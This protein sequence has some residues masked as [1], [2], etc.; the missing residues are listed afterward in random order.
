MLRD[1]LHEEK[2]MK[3]FATTDLCDANED[4]LGAGT[5]RVLTPVFRPFGRAERFAGPASTLKVFEDN[6]LVRTA[7][8]ENGDGR[9]LVIDGGGSIRCAIVGGNLAMLAE[10]NGW[11]GVLVYGAVRD[12]AELNAC[13]IGIRALAVHP[14]RSQKR[15]VGERDLAI[16]LP[17][18]TVRPGEWIYADADGILVSTTKLD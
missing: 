9:V 15:S 8:E 17:G 1:L 13:N 10:K 2:P 6:T 5:L 12:T 7:L 14:Q 4:R 16:A 3:A 18:T 11:A